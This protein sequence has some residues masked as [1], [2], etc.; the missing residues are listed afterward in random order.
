[1]Q[2]PGDLRPG[3]LTIQ[4]LGGY[5]KLPAE[6][7]TSKDLSGKI[8]SKARQ[9]T[10]PVEKSHLHEVYVALGDAVQLVF[11]NAGLSP[12]TLLRRYPKINELG[13]FIA[14]RLACS[15]RIR[16]PNKSNWHPIDK[17]QY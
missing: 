2:W 6:D 11:T 15:M 14:A 5:W 9:G 1:M 12:Q 3:T 7:L 16:D 4:W 17:Q 10:A 13:A 8:I